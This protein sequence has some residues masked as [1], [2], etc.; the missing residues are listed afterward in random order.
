MNNRHGRAARMHSTS[1]LSSRTFRTESRRGW[2]IMVSDSVFS[3]FSWFTQYSGS[4]TVSIHRMCL[5]IN[6]FLITSSGALHAKIPRA[7]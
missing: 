5:T 2:W 1:C 3:S 7:G 4:S 6:T